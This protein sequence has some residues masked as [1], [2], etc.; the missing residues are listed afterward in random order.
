[1][2]YYWWYEAVP[3]KPLRLTIC[4]YIG[5]TL[6]K[7]TYLQYPRQ[8]VETRFRALELHSNR[9]SRALPTRVPCARAAV[10]M[11]IYDN[12]CTQ[13]SIVCAIRFITKWFLKHSISRILLTTWVQTNIKVNLHTLNTQYNMA[14]SSHQHINPI[15]RLISHHYL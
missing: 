8:C 6:I 4:M 7:L 14:R 10:W 2:I 11:Y 3:R 1:M 5:G 9:T 13:F 12:V 15:K